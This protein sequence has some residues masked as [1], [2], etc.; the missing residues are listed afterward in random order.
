MKK[1]HKTVEIKVSLTIFDNDRRILIRIQE[2]QKHVDPVDPDPD[3]QHCYFHFKFLL[4][5]KQKKEKKKDNLF[6]ENKGE[7][8]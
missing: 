2:A 3:P 5:T 7:K 6:T 4:N 8:S 1:S